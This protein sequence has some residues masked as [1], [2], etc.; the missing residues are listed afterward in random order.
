[1]DC[2][3]ESAQTHVHLVNDAIQPS[4]LLSPASPPASI[5]PSIR[6]FSSESALYIRRPKGC[7]SCF[8]PSMNIQ[9]WVPLGLMG[10]SSPV[11]QIFQ[12]SS[13]EPQFKSINS[14]VLSLLYGP[15][16]TFIHDY[17]KNNSFNN[18]DI[19]RQSHVSAL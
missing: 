1:M 2:N 15:T 19:C 10:C 4:N 6:I 18:M 7:S 16:V 8:N 11:Q 17:L 9:G 5:F 13:P 14:L 12:K 3:S